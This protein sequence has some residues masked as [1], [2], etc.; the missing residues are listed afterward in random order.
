MDGWGETENRVEWHEAISGADVT[1]DC[2]ETFS[3]EQDGES[4]CPKCGWRWMYC[5]I[6]YRKAPSAF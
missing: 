3:I 2:G 4:V 1:C 5:V 6:V